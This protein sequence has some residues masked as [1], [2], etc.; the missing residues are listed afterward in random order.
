MKKVFLAL[1]IV[2]GIGSLSSCK[3]NYNCNCKIK[4]VVKLEQSGISAE[5]ETTSEIANSFSAKKKDA[6]S[7]CKDYEE[8]TTKD[9]AEGGATGTRTTT[10]TC[11]LQ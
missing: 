4:T 9:I 7:T 11:T 6:E 8:N 3:K 2:G 5:T 1:I 10:S